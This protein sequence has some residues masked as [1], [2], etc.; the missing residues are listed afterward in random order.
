L[1]GVAFTGASMLDVAD[2]FASVILTG[3]NAGMA[4]RTYVMYDQQ[5]NVDAGMHIHLESEMNSAKQAYK[6]A[7]SRL[8]SAMRVSV[9]TAGA[10]VVGCGAAFALP[11]P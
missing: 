5:P 7:V 10:S 9:L 3:R 6:D 11:T 2:A 4:E 1:I 8:A